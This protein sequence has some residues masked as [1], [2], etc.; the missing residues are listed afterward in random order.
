MQVEQVKKVYLGTKE[1]PPNCFFFVDIG[2]PDSHVRTTVVLDS[3]CRTCTF[4]VIALN[5]KSQSIPRSMF[6]SFEMSVSD[7]QWFGM[8]DYKIH[9]HAILMA[10]EM[11]HVK[12]AT[13]CFRPAEQLFGESVKLRIV[14][15]EN[16]KVR[17]VR[18]TDPVRISRPFTKDA[19]QSMVVRRD[20]TG[21]WKKTVVPTIAKDISPR[22]RILSVDNVQDLNDDFNFDFD[23]DLDVDLDVDMSAELKTVDDMQSQLV[24]QE[25]TILSLEEDLRNCKQAFL[26]P[27]ADPLN[28]CDKCLNVIEKPCFRSVFWVSLENSVVKFHCRECEKKA[29]EVRRRLANWYWKD[30]GAHHPMDFAK[31]VVFTSLHRD[32]KTEHVTV[33]ELSEEF[34]KPIY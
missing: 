31:R 16:G 20:S 12:K 13:F 19:K 27:V 23:M 3:V 33:E 10:P 14:C 1:S 2:R 32:G 8:C 22:E 34:D 29:K 21:V 17:C 11:N 5:S 4:G 30:D 24:D 25:I 6:S 7:S 26:A 9:G 28:R 15:F 18:E